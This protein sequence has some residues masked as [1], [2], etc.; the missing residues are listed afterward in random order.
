M[1]TAA[2][3]CSRETSVSSARSSTAGYSRL[4]V[5][6]QQ[7]LEGGGSRIH[8]VR[9]ELQR[10]LD[11]GDGFGGAL[12]PGRGF[13]QLRRALGGRLA[14]VQKRVER[15]V[16]RDPIA[17]AAGERVLAFLGERAEGNEQE[18][19]QNGTRVSS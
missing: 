14:A 3:F 8:V 1:R 13:Q 7:Q 18:R 9:G 17:E 19:E 6:F 16:D 5:L 15:A 10:F 4:R 2:S 12:R 11:G